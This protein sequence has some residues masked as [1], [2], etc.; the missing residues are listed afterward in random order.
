MVWVAAALADEAV[1]VDALALLASVEGATPPTEFEDLL[2]LTLA[3]LDFEDVMIVAPPAT[4][5]TPPPPV[6]PVF[7]LV[8]EPELVDPPVTATLMLLPEVVGAALTVAALPPKAEIVPIDELPPRGTGV[9]RTVVSPPL[10]D[11]G[12]SAGAV[13]AVNCAV[14]RERRAAS[15]S[16]LCE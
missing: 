4:L 6:L 13:E 1:A 11:V 14:E 3:L 7:V 16:R 12:S 2:L 9:G 10:V 5:P 8:I 15:M